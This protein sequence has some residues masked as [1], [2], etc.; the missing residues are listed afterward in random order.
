MAKRD[1]NRLRIRNRRRSHVFDILGIMLGVLF[2]LAEVGLFIVP[3]QYDRVCL[4]IMLGSAIASLPI[5]AYGFLQIWDLK[6]PVP[7]QRVTVRTLFDWWVL[8]IRR[9]ELG[10]ADGSTGVVLFRPLLGKRYWIHHL[11]LG[12]E[13][14]VDNPVIHY[15]PQ[16]V[17]EIRFSPDPKEDYIGAEGPIPL[18]QAAVVMDSG[19]E[20]RLIVNEA[21]AE[22]MRQWAADKGIVVCDCDGYVPRPL[23]LTKNA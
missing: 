5:V 19:K 6:R 13:I 10:P 16:A 3:R 2:F 7:T 1:P 18:C 22:R 8:G 15:P 14:E 11:V 23:Q 4:V 9:K 20:F 21:D 12:D 17:K